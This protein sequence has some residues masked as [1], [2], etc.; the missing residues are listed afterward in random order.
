MASSFDHE[1][2]SLML[3]RWQ[4]GKYCTAETE[5]N[6]LSSWR[7]SSKY[8]EPNL[9]WSALATRLRR[10]SFGFKHSMQYI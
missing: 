4:R 1:A 8:F 10:K 5:N 7:E 6:T 9:S 3:G 2:I